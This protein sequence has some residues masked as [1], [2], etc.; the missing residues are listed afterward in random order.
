MTLDYKVG[1][2]ERRHPKLS[3]EAGDE[4][5]RSDTGMVFPKMRHIR[6]IGSEVEVS[7]NSSTRLRIDFEEDLSP[8]L[9]LSDYERRA[10]DHAE[11]V[12]AELVKAAQ[13]RAAD[14]LVIDQIS[15]AINS[16]ESFSQLS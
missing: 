14:D 3:I 5:T 11:S 4:S 6:R 15:N 7:F 9:T 1:F 8:E 10:K 13:P 12:V 2:P 16:S